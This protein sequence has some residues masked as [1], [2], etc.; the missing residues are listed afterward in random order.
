MIRPIPYKLICPK[1]RFTKIVTPKSDSSL[2]IEDLAS[3][4]K[5]KVR[6]EIRYLDLECDK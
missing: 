6:M 3:C 2:I 4:P 5:C 1:C